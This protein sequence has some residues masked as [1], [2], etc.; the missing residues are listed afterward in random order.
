MTDFDIG[1]GWHS[2]RSCGNWLG[3]VFSF[4][5]HEAVGEL[6]SNHFKIAHLTILGFYFRVYLSEPIAAI[7]NETEE[8]DGVTGNYMRRHIDAFADADKDKVMQTINRVIGRL[9]TREELA[10]FIYNVLDQFSR[11]VELHDEQMEL[12]HGRKP[13]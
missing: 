7:R 8:C 10:L 12:W 11:D 5:T 6:T 1:V 9:S 2:R 4:V 3:W 13:N